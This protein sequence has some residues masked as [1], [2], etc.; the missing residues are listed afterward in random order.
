MFFGNKGV[1]PKGLIEGITYDDDGEPEIIT[2]EFT[3][4][5]VEMLNWDELDGNWT[6]RLNGI[7]FVERDSP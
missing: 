4:G 3:D 1:H 7:W 2:V 6:D 5:Q